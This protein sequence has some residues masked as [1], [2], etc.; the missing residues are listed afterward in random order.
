MGMKENNLQG[1][2]ETKATTVPLFKFSKT[3]YTAART[4]GAV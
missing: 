4:L 3:E 1:T 2:K